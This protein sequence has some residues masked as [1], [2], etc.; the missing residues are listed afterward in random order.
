[1]EGLYCPIKSS[2]C[3]PLPGDGGDCG[4]QGSYYACTPG[5]YCDGFPTYLCRP[6]RALGE[7]CSYNSSCLSN[8]CEYGAF[9]DG[10]GMGYR[11]VKCSQMAD[12]GS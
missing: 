9:P 5:Y 4:P 1:M 7:P 12:G 2:R 6:L 3:T 8:E 11:C 10:G